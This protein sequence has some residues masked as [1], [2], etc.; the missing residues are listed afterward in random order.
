[1]TLKTIWT[2][3]RID[4]QHSGSPSRRPLSLPAAAEE[5]LQETVLIWIAIVLALAAGV[6]GLVSY[7]TS[8]P[9]EKTPQG[10]TETPR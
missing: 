1:M 7:L 8:H 3:L 4:I 6:L 5:H 2:F 9:Q 10:S